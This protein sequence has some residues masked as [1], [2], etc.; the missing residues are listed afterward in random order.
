LELLRR[1]IFVIRDE[2]ILVVL[3]IQVRYFVAFN[4]ETII[5]ILEWAIFIVW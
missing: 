2:E 5:D 4:I 1:H 3:E